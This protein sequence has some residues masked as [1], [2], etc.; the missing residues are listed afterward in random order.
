MNWTWILLAYVS[1]FLFGLSDNLRGP[2]FA[3]LLREF[4][5]SNSRGSLFFSVSSLVS[6]AGALVAPRI[7]ARR[8]HL[9]S[10][11]IFMLLMSLAFIGYALSPGFGW[12]LFCAVF[13]GI[14]VGGLGVT[15]NLLVLQGASDANRGRAQGGLH[16]AYG[17]SSL[18]A[19]GIVIAV[20]ALELGWRVNFYVPAVLSLAVVGA[21]WVLQGR[22]GAARPTLE[23][24]EESAAARRALGLPEIYWAILLAAYVALELMISTRVTLL[25]R[26]A[27]AFELNAANL[28]TS[29]FFVGLFVG[30]VAYTVKPLPLGLGKQLALAMFLGAAMLALGLLHRPEWI[31]LAGFALS[32]FYP[33]WMT[34]LAR[35]FPDSFQR[36]ASLGI[37]LTGVSVVFM[38]TVIGGF[39]DAFGLVPAYAAV[40]ALAV[41][42]GLMVVGFRPLFRERLGE[43]RMP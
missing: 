21:V 41:V 26:E 7:I 11:W 23:E 29:V 4:S 27:F 30:R 25:L 40:P 31:P 10:L 16:A 6:M 17:L 13:F 35:V 14:S 39:T 18:L 22:A 19:P 34:T 24:H 32:I 20:A 3:D 33:V 1:L 8:G 38:H 15:Q 2:L 36:V 43:A 12:I 37:A 9:T 28:W 42:A 5:L